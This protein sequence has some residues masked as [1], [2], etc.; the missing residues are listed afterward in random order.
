MKKLNEEREIK[1]KQRKEVKK[2]KRKLLEE[3]KV[4]NQHSETSDDL[5]CAEEEEF[6]VNIPVS[7]PFEKLSMSHS[8]VSNMEND[9]GNDVCNG[10]IS[11]TS[12]TESDSKNGLSEKDKNEI[13]AYMEKIT[14]NLD[15][16]LNRLASRPHIDE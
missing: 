16:T 7:N 6:K 8:N 12:E 14:N 11:C 9:R 2:E 15:K 3:A 4:I 5:E 1:L 10:M 13:L